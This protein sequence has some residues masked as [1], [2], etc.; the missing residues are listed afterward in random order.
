MGAVTRPCC[1]RNEGRTPLPSSP[2]TRAFQGKAV[3][4]SVNTARAMA[5]PRGVASETRTVR[6]SDAPVL[7]LSRP[8]QTDGLFTSRIHTVT[9]AVSDSDWAA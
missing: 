9:A 4:G 7:T 3:L 8:D 6:P 2:Y 5:A 1:L